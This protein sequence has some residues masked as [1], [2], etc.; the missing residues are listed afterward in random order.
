MWRERWLRLCW[1]SHKHFTVKML[2]CIV[3][4]LFRVASVAVRVRHQQTE[5]G[6]A[7]SRGCLADGSTRCSC[8]GH[9]F[10]GTCTW[11]YTKKKHGQKRWWKL[12]QVSIKW[13][14]QMFIYCTNIKLDSNLI[15]PTNVLHFPNDHLFLHP[16]LMAP[17]AVC[18]SG[19]DA[20]EA[21][22]AGFFLTTRDPSAPRPF[23]PPTLLS[24]LSTFCFFTPR[25]DKLC[26]NHRRNNE[27]EMRRDKART[28]ATK[29]CF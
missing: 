24:Q 18:V 14:N 7:L 23:R 21:E 19:C 28:Q 17:E 5:R 29:T 1:G 3:F 11:N 13:N 15:C 25:E 22:L 9:R 26:R 20:A 12:C 6:A 27:W 16:F 8:R 2:H 4:S 10:D